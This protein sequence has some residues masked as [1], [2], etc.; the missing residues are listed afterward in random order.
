MLR[1]ALAAVLAACTSPAAAGTLDDLAGRSVVSNLVEE[2][3]FRLPNGER[4]VVR[5]NDNVK[6][7][8]STQG[9]IFQKAQGG[10]GPRD[11]QRQAN[12]VGSSEESVA[13]GR[14]S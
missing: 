12:V 7:Y 8:L 11:V 14:P 4:R 6:I 2:R 5:A 1:I 13:Q 3:V 10:S 9:R